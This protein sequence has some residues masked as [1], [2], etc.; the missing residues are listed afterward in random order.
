MLYVVQNYELNLIPALNDA[1]KVV[2]KQIYLVQESKIHDLCI[3]YEEIANL[4]HVDNFTLIQECNT[5]DIT[6]GSAGVPSLPGHL[7]HG[8]AMP[9]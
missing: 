3:E 9:A 5:V 6:T 8:L 2:T 4:D 7:P 1:K